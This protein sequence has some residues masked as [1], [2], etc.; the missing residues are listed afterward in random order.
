M[1]TVAFDVAHGRKRYM[2]RS[3]DLDRI[4]DEDLT[5]TRVVRGT[6][7]GFE[8]RRFP[9]WYGTAF[10][11]N[12]AEFQMYHKRSREFR[13]EAV[14]EATKNPDSLRT[15]GR[16][17]ITRAG[18]KAEKV[19]WLKPTTQAKAT[20]DEK[21]VTV[22]RAAGVVTQSKAEDVA[23]M[24]IFMHYV[25]L[26]KVCLPAN[27]GSPVFGVESY[28]TF[29]GQGIS[30]LHLEAIEKFY[31]EWKE[32]EWEWQRTRHALPTF[33]FDENSVGDGLAREE[34]DCQEGKILQARHALV[35]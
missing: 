27:A 5:I 9:M 33:E 25:L 34:M 28:V 14:V 23:D 4:D 35:Y 32:Y 8:L 24:P 19:N 17:F 26:M 21:L 11:R 20:L 6:R 29:G 30:G 18:M 31:E 7:T 22:S 12:E 16:F 1:V 2:R 3:V 15:D 10:L 13:R